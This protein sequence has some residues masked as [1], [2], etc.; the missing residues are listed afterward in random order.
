[1]SESIPIA[2]VQFLAVPEDHWIADVGGLG[3]SRPNVE[4]SVESR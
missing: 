1:V 3:G 2:L 4:G